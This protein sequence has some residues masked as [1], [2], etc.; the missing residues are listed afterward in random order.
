MSCKTNYFLFFIIMQQA[1][2]LKLIFLEAIFNDCYEFSNK[3]F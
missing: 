2:K 3:Y 1:F